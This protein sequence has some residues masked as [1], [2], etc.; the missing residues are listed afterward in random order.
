M[1]L[2]SSSLVVKFFF[3]IPPPGI[4]G[5]S[6]VTF[7][8]NNVE[9]LVNLSY[10]QKSQQRNQWTVILIHFIVYFEFKF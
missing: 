9:N 10:R 6:T 1:L 2:N 5:E 8:G 4:L 7:E 3:L